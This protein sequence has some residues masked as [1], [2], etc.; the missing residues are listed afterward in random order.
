MSNQY[1]AASAYSTVQMQGRL[2]GG[3]SGVE[4]VILLLEGVLERLTRAKHAIERKD[5]PEQV[6]LIDKLLEIISEGLRAH[7]DMESGGELAQQLDS[8]YGYCC[9]RLLEANSKNDVQALDEVY[10]LLEPLLAAWRELRNPSAG[11]SNDPLEAGGS[12]SSRPADARKSSGMAFSPLAS[13]LQ[14]AFAKA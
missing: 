3:G 7:L 1:R 10:G 6:K 9:F 14:N 11:G 5:R 8:L 4:L 13:Y 12:A 2:G